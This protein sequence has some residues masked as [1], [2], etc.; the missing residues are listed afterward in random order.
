M[1]TYVFFSDSDVGPL[2]GGNFDDAAHW[3]TQPQKW[4]QHYTLPE[5]P[6]SGLYV[7][8]VGG[9]PCDLEE[10]PAEPF[11]FVPKYER[12]RNLDQAEQWVH[13]YKHFAKGPYQ[14]GIMDLRSG[15]ILQIEHSLGDG[16][17]RR[18]TNGV[19]FDTY[20]GNWSAKLRDL[21]SVD[22]PLRHYYNARIGY[23]ERTIAASRS[24]LNV[25]VMWDVLMGHD[26]QGPVCQHEDSCPD[27][28]NF[29]T[30]C[31]TVLAPLL[32]RYWVRHIQDG[33][34]PC[35]SPVKEF[36]FEPWTYAGGSP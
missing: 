27:G 20:G 23:I 8:H 25:E 14:A 15:E 34:P 33:K 19:A 35:Q 31:G 9:S 24:T 18:V 6:A 36:T 26:P 10:E 30:L 21:T 12:A 29:I 28:V 2:I 13:Q 3:I 17:A 4:T 5:L 22:H 7:H 16:D 11:P 32:G 1:C